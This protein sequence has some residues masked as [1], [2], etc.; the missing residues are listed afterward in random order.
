MLK[1]IKHYMLSIHDV[2]LYP[3]ISFVLFFS[4]FSMVLIYVIV[5]RKSHMNMMANLPFE[6]QPDQMMNQSNNA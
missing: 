1:F 3:L 2:E 5:A 4:M 6:E